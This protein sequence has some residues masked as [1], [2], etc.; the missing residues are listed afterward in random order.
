LLHLL[1]RDVRF[2]LGSNRP[3]FYL[4]LELAGLRV[5][6]GV[7]VA[8]GVGDNLGILGVLVHLLLEAGVTGDVVVLVGAGL[9]LLCLVN[10]SVIIIVVR[11]SK[12]LVCVMER[13]LEGAAEVSLELLVLVPV[14][15]VGNVIWLTHWLVIVGIAIDISIV[16]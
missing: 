2:L 16:E 13:S 3:V 10:I 15:A 7:G 8:V 9:L 1:L 11:F 12:L 14:L 4:D 5:S 6:G